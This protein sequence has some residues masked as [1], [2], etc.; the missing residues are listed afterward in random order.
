MCI[1]FNSFTAALHNAV[2]S[3]TKK[4]IDGHPAF[5]QY[6]YFQREQLAWQM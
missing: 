3:Q 4:S 1:L 2:T 6:M 5:T